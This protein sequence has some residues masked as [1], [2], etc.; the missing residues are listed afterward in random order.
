MAQV[1]IRNIAHW[2]SGFWMHSGRSVPKGVCAL[3]KITTAVHSPQCSMPSQIWILTTA[4]MTKGVLS[5]SFPHS[6]PWCMFVVYVLVF[7]GSSHPVV[8]HKLL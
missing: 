2:G 7:E 5:L 4:Q 3:V 1:E 6:P 8:V